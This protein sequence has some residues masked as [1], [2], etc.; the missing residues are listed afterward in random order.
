MDTAGVHN[1][2]KILIKI[3]RMTLDE[4]LTVTHNNT[5]GPKSPQHEGA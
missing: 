5:I 4:S 3:T 2:P 1:T